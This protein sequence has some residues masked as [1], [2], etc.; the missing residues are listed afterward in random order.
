MC[1]QEPCVY[2]LSAA[3]VVIRN[4]N[5]LLLR[6]QLK[7]ANHGRK[8]ERGRG[9]FSLYK[10]YGI[11]GRADLDSQPRHILAQAEDCTAHLVF[12]HETGSQWFFNKMY[13]VNMVILWLGKT[14]KSRRSI[15]VI[16]Y[17]GTVPKDSVSVYKAFSHIRQVKMWAGMKWTGNTT[18]W[19][20]PARF[21]HPSLLLMR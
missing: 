4:T 19:S 5:K 2:L 14:D 7:Y 6:T 17:W 3:S 11:G 10:S 8:R 16:Q 13:N 21:T 20:D 15:P 1:V 18:L 12:M 9:Q